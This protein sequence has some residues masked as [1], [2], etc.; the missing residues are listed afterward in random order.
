MLIAKRKEGKGSIS[1]ASDPKMYGG[2][3]KCSCFSEKGCF[4]NINLDFVHTTRNPIKGQQFLKY[5]GG[6]P[7]V[8]HRCSK[9]H[10]QS[11]LFAVV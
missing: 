3:A 11:S 5:A 9:S 7:G 4:W 1:V 8:S 10:G 6:K 2:C